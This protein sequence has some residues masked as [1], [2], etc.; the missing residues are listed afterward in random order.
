[1]K[2]SVSVSFHQKHNFYFHHQ[3]LERLNEPRGE[4]RVKEGGA[5]ALTSYVVIVTD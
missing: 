4:F 2:N 1:M 5:S 3:A